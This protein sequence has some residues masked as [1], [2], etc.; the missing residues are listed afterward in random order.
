M[1]VAAI[2]TIG[3]RLRRATRAQAR[4]ASKRLEGELSFP[5]S[6]SRLRP[7]RKWFGHAGVE[8]ADRRGSCGP[9]LRGVEF[10]A[11]E[12]VETEEAFEVGPQRLR[13]RGGRPRARE[14]GPGSRRRRAGIRSRCGS[15]RRSEARGRAFD[16]PRA[17]GVLRLGDGV[18][19]QSIGSRA[20]RATTRF[21]R[22]G[23]ARERGGADVAEVG[24]EQ[25]VLLAEAILLEPLIRL[26]RED[27]GLGVDPEADVS[28]SISARGVEMSTAISTSAPRSSATSIGRL[29]ARY[30]STSN[31]PSISTG[32]KAAG[33]DML[34]RW[35]V[36]SVP[37]DRM[38]ASPVRISVATAR[39]GRL[40]SSMRATPFLPSVIV[41]SR[42]SSFWP[43]TTPA[44]RR[45]RDS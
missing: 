15:R 20:S 18:A 42:N 32:V 13:D 31:R 19:R 37:W 38:T 28:E 21:D 35:A 39:K 1:F 16:G 24:G 33:I 6:V 9:A 45:T 27:G 30:P 11:L 26:R 14:P 12:G 43:S 29:F 3:V 25:D 40:R 2:G 23:H 34:A 41:R 5:K 17:S 10:D 44:G 7:T 36:A 22:L 4:Q 8:P